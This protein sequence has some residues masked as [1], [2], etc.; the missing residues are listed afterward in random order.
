M[1]WWIGLILLIALL[2]LYSLCETASRA[3]DEMDKWMDEL[4]KKE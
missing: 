3:D 1:W 4:L 2:V